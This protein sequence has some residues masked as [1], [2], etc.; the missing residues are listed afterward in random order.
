MADDLSKL[1]PPLARTTGLIDTDG[2]VVVRVGEEA[3]GRCQQKMMTGYVSSCMAVV[4][5][6]DSLGDGESLSSTAA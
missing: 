6:R 1:R 3:R 4:V 5:Y 2:F